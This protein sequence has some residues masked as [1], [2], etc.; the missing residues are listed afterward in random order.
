MEI[1]HILRLK[2]LK[3]CFLSYFLFNEL[4]A[5]KQE[6]IRMHLNEKKL[7]THLFKIK[8]E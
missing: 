5:T 2:N 4:T 7:K 6:K 8:E 1:I 3:E